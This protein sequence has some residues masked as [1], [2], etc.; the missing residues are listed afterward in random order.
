MQVN[1]IVVSIAG[2][3]LSALAIIGFLGV[4]YMKPANASHDVWDDEV[5][6]MAKNMYWESRNQTVEGLIAVGNVVM[7]RVSDNR[8]PDTVCEVI[9]QGPTYKSWKDENTYY[10]IKNKCQFSWYCDGKT[11]EIPDNDYKIFEI[12]YDIA[13]KVEGGY[14][15]DRTSGATHYHA[16]YVLPSWAKTKTRTAKIADHI[17][18]RWEK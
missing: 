7:N 1:K 2:N 6:C 15:E 11:D 3:F 16:Y 12:I 13:M 4:T 17:F 10:P 18:Y 8:Y 5:L 14:L 9:E